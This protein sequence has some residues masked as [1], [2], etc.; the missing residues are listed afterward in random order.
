MA[1][2]EEARAWACVQGAAAA[3]VARDAHDATGHLAGVGVRGHHERGVGPAEA[4]GHAEALGRAHRDV[5]A[6]LARGPQ[7][8][9]GQQIVAPGMNPGGAWLPF[10]V[11]RLPTLRH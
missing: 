10:L 8:G 6:D 7:Q 11:S 3:P 9:Q 4:H 2:A 1:W 5:G